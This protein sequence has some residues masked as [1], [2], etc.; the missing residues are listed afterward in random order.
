MQA[1]AEKA[2]QLDPM[3]A[4][5]HAAL[6]MTYAQATRY[7]DGLITECQAAKEPKPPRH[8]GGHGHGHGRK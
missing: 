8:G 7:V 5:A 6:G 4:E 3:L 2:I 1:T